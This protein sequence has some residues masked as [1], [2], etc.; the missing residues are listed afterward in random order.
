M[1]SKERKQGRYERRNARREAKRNAALAAYDDFNNI[2]DA[3]NLFKSFL[4]SRR[5]VSWKESVQRYEAYILLNIAEARRKL[6][7]GESVQSGFVE[8]S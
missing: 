8:F 3:D 1:T 4:R 2:A 5:G 6:L 7:A